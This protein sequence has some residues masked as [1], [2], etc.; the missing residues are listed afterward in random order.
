MHYGDIKLMSVFHHT[1]KYFRQALEHIISGDVEVEKLITDTLPLKD[2]EF[3]M[4]QHI[5]GNAIKY[6]IKP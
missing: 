6:L 1:P 2:V 4:K 3:A 5:A